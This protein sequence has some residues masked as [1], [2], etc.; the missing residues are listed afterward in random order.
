MSQTTSFTP[1]MRL[2]MLNFDSEPK[3]SLILIYG[4]SKK[5]SNLLEVLC[6]IG[7]EYQSRTDDLSP[8]RPPS[9]M[10]RTGRV[11]LDRENQ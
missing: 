7:G 2:S 5:A 3:V 6:S 11:F 9:A 1:K 10:N 4:Q 8:A